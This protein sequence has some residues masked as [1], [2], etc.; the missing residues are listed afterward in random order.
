MSAHDG[1][2]WAGLRLVWVLLAATL[3]SSAAAEVDSF[4]LAARVNGVAITNETLERNFEEFLKQNNVNVAT[5]RNPERLKAMKRE[6]LDLLIGQELVWQAAKRQGMVASSAEVAVGIG[7]VRAQFPTQEAFVSRL[8]IEGY[9]EESYYQHML[10][11]ASGRKYLEQFTDKV[12]VSDDEVHAFYR[13]NPD[14][15]TI[16]EQIVARHVLLKLGPDATPEAKRAAREKLEGIRAE[17]LSGADFAELAR[18]YS[19]DASAAEGGDLGRFGRGR[20]VAPFEQA[21]F[22]LQP[23]EISDIVE[24]Q[25]G[26]HLIRV[27]ERIPAQVVAEEQARERIRGYLQGQKAREAVDK[28]IAELRSNAEV[29]I[30]QPL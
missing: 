24:T 28:A 3:I 11:L 7:Q 23:G 9:T 27:D 19:E 25:F 8:A 10:R 20:M 30:L 13:D 21:A 14:K 26:L 5:I 17:A 1:A 22:A 18:R 15:F 4:S 16:P 2:G 29:E 6:T 12:Q